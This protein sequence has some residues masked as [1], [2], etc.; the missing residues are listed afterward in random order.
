M[1]VSTDFGISVL[2][3]INHHC[4]GKANA[5]TSKQIAFSFG[6]TDRQI[7]QA[8]SELRRQEEPIVSNTKDGF[9]I[10]LTPGEAMEIYHIR[11]RAYEIFTTYYGLE[12]GIQKR[13]PGVVKQMKLFDLKEIA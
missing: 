6:T 11:N 5:K 2:D 13:F 7:R 4:L 12:R 8:V 1:V 10:P 9:F 3:Y